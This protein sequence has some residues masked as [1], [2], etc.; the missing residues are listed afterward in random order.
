[1]VT[2]SASRPPTLEGPS[3]GGPVRLNLPDVPV[4][5]SLAPDGWRLGNQTFPRGPLTLRAGDESAANGLGVNGRRY[6]GR[7]RLLPRG[8]DPVRFDVVNDLDLEDYLMGLLPRELPAEWHAAAFRAQAVVAR[9]YAIWE[10]K[11]AGSTRG[12]FDV[13]DDDKSQV[14]GGL[15]AEIAKSRAAVAATR[16][17][18]VVHDTPA[19]PRIFKAYFFSTCGGVTLGVDHAFNEPPLQALSAQNLGDS[20]KDS[21]YYR[22][23]PVV[24]T[25]GEMTRRVRLW[26]KSRGHSVATIATI[27]RLEIAEKNEFGRPTRF[28]LVDV[29]GNRYSLIPEEIRWCINT[30]ATPGTGVY[31]GFFTPIN[32]ATN[33]VISDGRGWGHGVG[34]CQ[35]GAEHWA[36]EGKDHV[37]IVRMSYPGTQVV[38]AY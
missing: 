11:T 13:Y 30:D 27:D 35:F 9:T 2:L 1:M 7:L 25:K 28:E 23:P 29:K 38:R 31:S 18:V 6:R 4:A 15:D 20:C 36:A 21:K 24:L 10:L 8:D 17:Q 12:Y 14:Y 16:G 32:N 3:L 22:W 19:G 26:G 34:M 5:L 33:I 37:E